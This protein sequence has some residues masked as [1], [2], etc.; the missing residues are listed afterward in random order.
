MRSHET[1][2]AVECAVRMPGPSSVPGVEWTACATNISWRRRLTRGP[3]PATSG[4]HRDARDRFIDATG[5][6]IISSNG[7]R[8]AR[9]CPP[10]RLS[11]AR[12]HLGFRRAATRGGR[13][14]LCSRSTGAA[15]ATRSGSAPAATTTFPTMPP[16][17]GDR[18]RGRRPDG[19]RR[20]FDGAAGRALHGTAPSTVTA[21]ACIDALGPPDMRPEDV[22]RRYA[23]GSRPRQDGR[24]RAD[25][26]DARRR[27]A[28][29]ASAFR[30]SR[31]V[32]RTSHR[33]ELRTNGAAP[34]SSIRCTRRR[35]RRRTTWRQRA[36][37]GGGSLSPSS[38]SRRREPDR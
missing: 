8:R 35:H 10:A 20:T 2:I 11:R 7:G 25:D 9:R 37:S 12:A 28:A 5:S 24:T 34:G 31:T 4:C 19:A 33:T 3:L 23:S 36:R 18:A 38:T 29:S 15:T 6:G 16:T 1:R 17:R 30:T 27:D 22:P 26:A 32:R 21:L 13:L 14:P